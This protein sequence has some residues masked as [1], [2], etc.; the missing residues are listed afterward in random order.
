[1]GIIYAPTVSSGAPA[2]AAVSEGVFLS[3]SLIS[4][5]HWGKYKWIFKK[6]HQFFI[7]RILLELC[8]E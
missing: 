7:K 4:F 3:H 6:L 5:F 8:C 1:V 2:I